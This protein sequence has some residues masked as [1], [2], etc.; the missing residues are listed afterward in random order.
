MSLQ[1]SVNQTLQSAAAIRAFKKNEREKI[2]KLSV[3]KETRK[4][5][6]TIENIPVDKNVQKIA[7][8]RVSILRESAKDNFSNGIRK[9]MIWNEETKQ[10]RT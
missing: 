4:K 3:P 1:S 2:A 6:K 9:K 5:A 7:M 10:W 8:Q